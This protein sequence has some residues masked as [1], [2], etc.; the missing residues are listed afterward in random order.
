MHLITY[1]PRMTE[2]FTPKPGFFG[3]LQSH[4]DFVSRFLANSFTST[5]DKWLQESLA[6]SKKQLGETWLE[7]YLSSPIWHFAISSGICGH[8]SSAG[9]LMPSVDKV[10][11]YFPLT[12]A[13]ILPADLTPIQI[14]EVSHEAGQRGWFEKAKQL[15]LST[16]SEDFDFNEFEKQFETLGSPLPNTLEDNVFLTVGVNN[17]NAI[18]MTIPSCDDFGQSYS[19]LA[20]YALTVLYPTSSLWWTSGSDRVTPSL[21][22]CNGLPPTSGFSAFLDGAWG[23]W[24]WCEHPASNGQSA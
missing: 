6:A 11:R 8:E 22:A 4:G 15:A 9:V 7:T 12:I 5:W 17:N 2:K 1:E 19:R 10:G 18:H 13:V 20:N 23:R 21:L 24:G 16:L 14:Y 3:K